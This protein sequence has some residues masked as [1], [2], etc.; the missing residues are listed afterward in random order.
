MWLCRSV[1]GP[2]PSPG[3]GCRWGWGPG[4]PSSWFRWLHAPSCC[5][6]NE[7]MES[8][9]GVITVKPRGG[10]YHGNRLPPEWED[11]AVTG[12]GLPLGAGQPGCLCLG[13][14]LWVWGIPWVQN[15][16]YF[17]KILREKTEI[18]TKALRLE[19]D[20]FRLGMIMERPFKYFPVV[21]TRYQT[22]HWCLQL[23][24][25]GGCGA[26]GSGGRAEGPGPGAGHARLP[27][28]WGVPMTPEPAHLVSSQPLGMQG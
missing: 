2:A 13:S 21:I 3:T 12:R 18:L 6:G 1:A 14:S 8:L 10:S 24:G 17:L 4:C 27:A 11:W 22:N 23:R 19:V 15:K 25:P 5:L 20:N 7:A 28:Q 26:P 16:K 9:A